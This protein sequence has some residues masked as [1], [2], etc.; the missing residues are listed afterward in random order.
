MA[1]FVK[2]ATVDEIAVGEILPLTVHHRDIVICR[3]VEGFFAVA[4]ECPHDS[5]PI[6]LGH[7][8]GHE[9]VCPRH[10]A[11]FD[12]ATGDVTA[13]PAVVGIETYEVKVENNDIFV[14]LN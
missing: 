5:S 9:V 11:R 7:V 10:G 6:A 1:D 4:D 13:P 14:R 2:V 8:D 3:T 12:L